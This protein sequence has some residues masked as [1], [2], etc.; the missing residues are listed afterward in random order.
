MTAFITLCTFTSF[1]AVYSSGSFY[2]RYGGRHWKSAFLLTALLFP[3]GG[4]MRCLSLTSF[5]IIL[6]ALSLW[7]QIS[8]PLNFAET[9]LEETS[10]VPFSTLLSTNWR[11]RPFRMHLHLLCVWIDLL[12]ECLRLPNLWTRIRPKG[13]QLAQ[14][15]ES[16]YVGW[17]RFIQTEQEDM[18]ASHGE[19]SRRYEQ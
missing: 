13:S 18:P 2:K 7:I 3:G 11:S 16:E 1:V 12:L 10:H 9:H 17:S 8:C 15:H 5:L 6:E 14:T 19:R 4:I